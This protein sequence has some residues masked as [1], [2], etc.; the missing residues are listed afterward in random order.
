MK[1]AGCSYKLWD[2]RSEEIPLRVTCKWPYV[3][4]YE[5]GTSETMKMFLNCFACYEQS[6]WPQ[7]NHCIIYVS[8]YYIF[9]TQG[10]SHMTRNGVSL[11]LLHCDISIKRNKWRI[12]LYS[13][14]YIWRHTA[15]SAHVVTSIKQ[16]PVLRSYIFLV[17][18][19]F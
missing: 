6:D 19:D 17:I 11:D 3:P 2:G 18:D 8:Y 9:K 10:Q 7:K 14:L 16:S 5:N 13:N 15:K 1:G 4:S 12:W